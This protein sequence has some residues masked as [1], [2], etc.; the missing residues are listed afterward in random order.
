MAKPKPSR[1]ARIV[2]EYDRADST[3]QSYI[4]AASLRKETADLLASPSLRRGLDAVYLAGYAAE[5]A[6]KA[7][8]LERTSKNRREATLDEISAG[9]KAHDLQKLRN[10]LILRGVSV[11]REVW[12]AID[13]ICEEWSTDLRYVAKIP[14][15]R[16]VAQFLKR[17]DVVLDWVG[18]QRR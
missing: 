12:E 6:L 17:V 14:P 2:E 15:E 13:R 4:R 7:L 9:A 10:A 1:L 16:E 5:C 11:P 3:P 8:I 18:G